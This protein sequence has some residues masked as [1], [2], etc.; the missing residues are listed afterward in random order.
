VLS[1]IYRLDGCTM[2]ELAEFTAVDRTT[3]T[4]TLDQLC[5]EGRV[6]RIEDPTDRRRVRL[7]L[8]PEGV[9]L[10]HACSR[11]SR[12]LARRHLADISEADRAAVSAIMRTLIEAM[13]PDAEVAR[14][15]ITL[16]R[17]ELERA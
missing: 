1:V 14:Q 8:T 5:A 10:R 16:R 9:G 3:T 12:A 17:P 2:G 13:T 4:R 11:I 7:S 15:V 6:R